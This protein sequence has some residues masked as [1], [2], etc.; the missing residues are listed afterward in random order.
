D[1]QSVNTNADNNTVRRLSSSL[2]TL[3]NCGWYWGPM[4]SKE[5]EK[6]LYNQPDGCFLVRDSENDYHLLSVSFRSKG[7]TCHTRLIYNKG[8]F[9]FFQDEMG[10]DSAYELIMHA[11]EASQDGILCNSR[12]HNRNTICYPVR[13]QVPIS[14]FNTVPPLQ[15]L[16]RFVIRQNIRCDQLDQLPLPKQI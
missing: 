9:S 12:G 3:S 10:K 5:A 15:F 11:M 16:C 1:S 8:K 6:E 14:R 2:K 4:S 13:L 7:A